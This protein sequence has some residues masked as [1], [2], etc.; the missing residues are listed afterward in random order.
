MTEHACVDCGK[1]LRER[2]PYPLRHELRW[3]HVTF[4]DA[5][6]CGMGRK[7]AWPVPA[8]VV[9]VGEEPR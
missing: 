1:P 8:A 9:R 7:R 2:Y 6:T 3:A 5:Q 4:E